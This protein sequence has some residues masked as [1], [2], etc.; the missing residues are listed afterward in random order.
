MLN[1]DPI[2]NRLE[3]APPGPWTTDY[4][5]LVEETYLVDSKGFIGIATI[6][7]TDIIEPLLNYHSDMQALINEVERLQAECKRYRDIFVE[8][9]I[10]LGRLE[11]TVMD[12]L[13]H[14]GYIGSTVDV[15]KIDFSKA[16]T[17]PKPNTEK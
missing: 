14:D 16:D 17:T 10:T 12:T 15:S 11:N 4:D 13:V 8:L 7:S 6:F 9:G 2:K 3:S 5:E 1:L